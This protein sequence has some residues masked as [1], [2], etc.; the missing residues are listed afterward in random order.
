[1]KGC[2]VWSQPILRG[3]IYEKMGNEK[4]GGIVSWVGSTDGELFDA[5]FVL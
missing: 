1:M 3:G 2:I 4:N 5:V